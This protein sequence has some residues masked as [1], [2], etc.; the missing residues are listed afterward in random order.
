[1]FGARRAVERH[2][3]AEAPQARGA[4][5][6]EVRGVTVSRLSEVAK[7]ALHEVAAGQSREIHDPILQG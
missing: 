2:V 6:H 1:M 5:Q 4:N 7:T 3:Q